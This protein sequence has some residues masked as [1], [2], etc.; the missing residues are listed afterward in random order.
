MC[1]YLIFTLYLC[2]IF[3][4]CLSS[5]VYLYEIYTL[6]FFFFYLLVFG[7]KLAYFFIFILVFAYYLSFLSNLITF[8]LTGC[9][10]HVLIFSCITYCTYLALTLYLPRDI[11]EFREAINFV[12]LSNFILVLNLGMFLAPISYLPL[13][14]LTLPYLILPYH[15]LPLLS[16]R[17]PAPP[18]STVPYP[19]Q[20]P[21]L[22]ME[23]K[24]VGETHILQ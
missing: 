20:P 2:F 23:R 19:T 22:S 24:P 3:V 5:S 15:T 9:L 14:Q 13:P 18:N 8:F 21:S 11:R 7:G 12:S 10:Y 17:Y 1:M 6:Y 4:L 16:V